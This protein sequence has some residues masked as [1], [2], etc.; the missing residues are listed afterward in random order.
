MN[1]TVAEEMREEA[2]ELLSIYRFY[3]CDG[4]L[5]LDIDDEKL[6]TLF[7]TITLSITQCGVLKAKLPYREFV[8]PSQKYTDNE[9]SWR[10]H[11]E[12]RDNRRFFLS[13]VHDFLTLFFNTKNRK[14][15]ISS[16][17]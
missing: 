6:D 13:D 11:F 14:C 1:K 7:D 10:G 3:A 8:Q 15:N 17:G 16:K 2:M 12:D 5:Y 9:Q 4:N